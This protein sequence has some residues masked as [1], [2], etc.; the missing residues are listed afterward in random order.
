MYKR[1]SDGFGARR[2]F[3][4]VKVGEELDVTIEAV[5]EK[6]DGIAKKDGFVLFVPGVKQGEQ[7][8]IRV[9]KVLRKVGFAEVVA[10]GAAAEE[11]P[12]EGGSEEAAAEET[13]EAPAEEAGTDSDEF[14]DSEE[15]GEESEAQ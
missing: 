10:K 11:A 14:G 9:T 13:T 4:P 7:V 6:G 5:G 12:E 15:F 8:H 1:E 2:S 3:A